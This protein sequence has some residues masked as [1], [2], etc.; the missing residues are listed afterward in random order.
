M[1]QLKEIARADKKS[2]YTFTAMSL[3]LGAVIIAQAYFIVVIVDSIFLQGASFHDVLAPIGWLA[4]ALLGRAYFSYVSGKTGVKLAAKAKAQFRKALLAKYARNPLLGSLK[5]QSGEKVSIL[6]DAVD[7]VDDYFSKYYP[8]LIQT[9][10]VPIMIIIAIFWHNWL[11]AVI[12]LVTSPFIPIFMIVIGKATQKKSEEQLEKL[13]KFSGKFL[14][15]LQ[16]LTTL[17][18]L[19]RA[20]EKREAIRES[21]IEYRDATMTV[22]KIAF[23]SSLMLEFISMLGIALVALEVGLRL[24]IYENLTFFTAFFVLILVPEYFNFLKELGSAFH[25][26][27]GSMGAAQ[28]I[29]DDLESEEK[30]V[31]WGGTSLPESSE[32][33]VIEL[34]NLQFHY[35]SD[36]GFQLKNITAAIPSKS[37]VAI[38]GRSG[39]GKTTLLHLLSG[40]IPPGQGE[41]LVNGKRLYE[42]KEN[43]WYNHLSYISQNPYL[44]AGTIRENIAVGGIGDVST[45]EIQLAAEKA[46]ILEMVSGLKDGFDTNVGEGGRGLSGGEKQRIALA[47]AFLKKPSIILF[48]E[49]TVGLDLHTERILQRS[50][51]ELAKTSTVITVAHRLHTIREAD[52]ILFLKDGKLL[53]KG[54]HEEL[55]A[56]QSEYRSMVAVHKG[57]N[58]G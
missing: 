21:S 49:P 44:F 48:D 10:I 47:R 38:V 33:P 39:S 35:G 22:L 26:G 46:G 31:Q 30:P 55:M 34:Q 50:M 12:I 54:T 18:L 3:L 53:A 32:P 40:M 24:V 15:I 57:G 23:V 29:V 52:Q 6:L 4:A 51:R 36:G 37:N 28:K 9:S 11:S 56:K 58:T 42:Y 27:R 19:G 16:G 5:G 20:K 13:A 1:K 8:Q 2:L 45:A 43:D 7:G 14:D 25:S 17:K 41:I